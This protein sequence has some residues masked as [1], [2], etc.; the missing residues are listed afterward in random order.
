MAALEVTTVRADTNYNLWVSNTMSGGFPRDYYDTEWFLW[1]SQ[2][3]YVGH[4]ALQ[5]MVDYLPSSDPS[6]D[7]YAVYVSV[8]MNPS[9]NQGTGT[10]RI[11]SGQVRI[12]MSSYCTAV[13]YQPTTSVG[14]YSYGITATIGA[15]PTFSAT[16][17]V[18]Y[19]GIQVN[20]NMLLL[21]WGAP[22]IWNYNF[23]DKTKEYNLI[24]T[25]LIRVQKY[26]SLIASITL[27]T[28]WGVYGWFSWYYTPSYTE[29][30]EFKCYQNTPIT[31]GGCP[32]LLVWN[33]SAYADEGLLNI[34]NLVAPESDVAVYH[35][36]NTA[37]ALTDHRL[38]RLELYEHPAGYNASH[39]W[40]NQALLYAVD[41]NGL[42]HKCGLVSADLISTNGSRDG[43]VLSLLLYSDTKVA[44]TYYGDK[45]V[46]QFMAPY[47]PNTEF[48]VFELIGHNMK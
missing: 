44:Q 25:T 30:T 37:P 3:Y 45:I 8:D 23:N 12:D 15:N 18:T 14:S 2:T 41:K 21:N 38:Y 28:T 40:L 34:H 1:A 24:F 43:S 6:Y 7:Y 13:A 27:K 46:L 10:G 47:V 11:A 32:N 19:P 36:L 20:P 9:V 5:W 48:F 26:N 31:G 39:S 33:G 29:Y 4:M 35:N 16:N 17:T 42:C 22:A